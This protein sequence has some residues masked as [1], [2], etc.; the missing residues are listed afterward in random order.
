[1]PIRTPQDQRTRVELLQ[2]LVARGAGR[3]HQES[4]VKPTFLA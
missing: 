4:A 2:R 3:W 1:M